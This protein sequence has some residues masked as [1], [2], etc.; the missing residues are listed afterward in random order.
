VLGA[1]FDLRVALVTVFVAWLLGSLPWIG[2]RLRPPRHR[3]FW[4]SYWML[5]CA[6]WAAS[7]ALDAGHYAYL[8]QRLS[9][10]LI[11]LAQ[12]AGEA[13]GMVWQS[14]PVLPI[15]GLFA[16]WLVVCALVFRLL[17]RLAQVGNAP[18][19][20]RWG[21]RVA[22]FAVLLLAIGAVH[23]K[24]SQYPLRW[25]DSGELPN[26]FAQQ[27][28][29]NPQHN[30]YDTWAFREQRI[31]AARMRTDA[32]AIRSFVGLPPLAAAEP[33]S[34]LRAVP[35][36]PRMVG[37]PPLNVVV[38]LL[39]SFA[40]H[41]VGALGSPMGATPVFDAM[42]RDGLLF[43]RMMSAHAHTA[44]GVFATITGLPDVSRR[45]T[46]TRNPAATRQHTIAAEF[47]A[48]RK[49]YFTGG[50]TSWANVRGLL[51][52]SLPGIDI[53]EQD[54]LR[55]PAVDVW[56]VSDKNLFIEAHQIL[57]EQQGPFFAVIQTS[58]NHRPY[59]IPKEDRDAFAPNVP[60]AD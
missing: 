18:P 35:A 59:T 31:D 8:A 26:L 32:D 13:A 43:T 53:V 34:F 30:L 19:P 9:A 55:A 37:R 24:A 22:E 49:L 23:G 7:M 33:I 51:A 44:R 48:H 21:T 20:S 41:K 36:D 38:V 60:G 46:A 16:G 58:G 25:S 4:W 6:V 17:W 5:A 2:P 29:L 12:D 47:K 45:G 10:V 1:R 57:S 39:E 40:G 11:T 15:L 54:R 50:S 42:A 56:G 52:S 27:L 14:Y 3:R 28:A